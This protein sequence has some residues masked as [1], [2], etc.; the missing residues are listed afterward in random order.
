VLQGGLFGGSSN[1]KNIVSTKP[2]GLVPLFASRGF[3]RYG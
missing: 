2:R 1:L 3:G